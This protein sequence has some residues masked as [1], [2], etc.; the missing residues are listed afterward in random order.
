ML[1]PLLPTPYSH[2]NNLTVNP[3]LK[4]E[5]TQSFGSDGD[6]SVNSGSSSAKRQKRRLSA[7]YAQE[8][9]SKPPKNEMETLREENERLKSKI[10]DL[11]ERAAAT[12]KHK[13][14][15]YEDE[16]WIAREYIAKL[17]NMFNYHNSD[18]DPRSVSPR[19]HEYY[20]EELRIKQIML[21]KSLATKMED[22][23]QMSRITEQ[24]RISMVEE[25]E[26]LKRRQ[27]AAQLAEQ[28]KV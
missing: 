5:P 26:R 10:K 12:L 20:Q 7:N 23:E 22:E 15:H 11:E 8:L 19:S 24:N 27:L 17:R 21:N 3:A 2:L 16:L 4:K 6:S 28:E 18:G 1:P 13:Q 9:W 14:D 25:E